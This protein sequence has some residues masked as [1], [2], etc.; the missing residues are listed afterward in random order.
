[1]RSAAPFSSAWAENAVSAGEPGPAGARHPEMG[2]P[3]LV[4]TA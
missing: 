1:M 4:G 2:R 3:R